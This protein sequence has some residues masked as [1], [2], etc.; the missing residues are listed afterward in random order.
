MRSRPANQR[1]HDIA[2]VL[3]ERWQITCH[4]GCTP[5][6]LFSDK[7]LSGSFLRCACGGS[8]GFDIHQGCHV[9]CRWSTRTLC[10]TVWTWSDML[11]EFSCAIC[12]LEGRSRHEGCLVGRL[13]QMIQI[14][15]IYRV[16]F[17][18][19]FQHLVLSSSYRPFLPES[20]IRDH[21]GEILTCW[22]MSVSTRLPQPSEYHTTPGIS[23][24]Q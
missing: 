21:S 16:P 1:S 19:M 23:F 15:R 8:P 12:T 17:E 20:W 9:R 3:H 11:Q 4:P 5:V 22:G 6:C 24:R 2:Y 10:P 14:I 18:W 13:K 7:T